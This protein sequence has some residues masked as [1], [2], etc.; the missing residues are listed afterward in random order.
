MNG[1]KVASN[2]LWRLFE[3]SGTQVVSLY[4]SIV[5]ARLLE[6]E[7]YGKI[8]LITVFTSIMGVFI[9]SGM[10]SSLIQKKNVDET[11]YSTVFY[12]NVAT[13]ILMYLIMF[14]GAPWIAEFY[15]D[16]ELTLVIRVNSLSLL[17]GGVANVLNANVSK[18]MLFKR[19]FYSTF[20]GTAV[21][22]VCG[23]LMAY[24]GFGI[25]ALVGQHLTNNFVGTLALWICIK[26]KPKW[27]FSFERLKGLLSY[28]WKLL[29]ATLID[30]I[31]I[32]IRQLIIGKLYSSSD[33]AFYNKGNQFPSLVNT[34]VNQSI[35]AVLFPV[36]SE[37]QD[38][39]G[40]AKEIMRRSIKTS[41]YVMAPLLIGLAAVSK[42]FVSF[43]L[44]DKWAMSIPFLCI[45]CFTYLLNP[46][47]TAN[48][49]AIKALGRSD[50]CLKLEVI[51]KSVGFISILCTLKL[52]P[53]AICV[54]ELVSSLIYPIINAWPNKK[55][56]G[57]NFGEQFKD[58][59][60]NIAM[61]G[62][63]GIV[64]WIIGYILILPA[65]WELIIQVVIG[66]A[67]YI[68]SSVIFKSEAY[69][70]IWRMIKSFIKKKS[71]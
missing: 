35:E 22:A 23:L 3:R 39:K 50:L 18:R 29:V 63:M 28:G 2:F 33:L 4:V 11:D 5:L 47:Q 46:I 43:V 30:A 37:S 8:A 10:A 66:A 57:Y 19:H 44:T 61:A 26:W 24:K 32:D 13:S 69:F 34:N 31:Y 17:I 58:V 15:N 51:R 20:I 56:L 62:F 53:L 16:T 7:H 40:R 27:C 25:W 48:L 42:Q 21:S 9:R 41:T 49:N 12:Y 59:L 52:G 54:G 65:Y 6:P 64:V 36:M 67:I 71:K 14:V 68:T 55:L 45:F 70:Y 38:N 60:P 1:K